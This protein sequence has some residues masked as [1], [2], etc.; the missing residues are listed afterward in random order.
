MGKIIAKSAKSTKI[1]LLSGLV[2]ATII[3]ILIAYMALDHD[4][5]QVYSTNIPYLWGLVL[6]SFAFVFSPFGVLAVITEFI[7]RFR[8]GK[9]DKI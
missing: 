1:I 4:P 9:G 3:A 7:V 5:Q 6:L 2:V 8:R